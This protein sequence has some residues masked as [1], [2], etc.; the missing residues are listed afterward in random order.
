MEKELSVRTQILI[1]TMHQV[2]TSILDKM[3]I[4][5]DAVVINQ[6]DLENKRNFEYNGY[7]ITWIDTK[8][9]GLSRSRNMALKNATAEY[10]IIADDDEEFL[11]QSID[12]VE[13]AFSEHQEY[14]LLRFKI[15]GI[16][17]IFKR[18]P[19]NEEK[20][21]WIR[22]M[23]V[24]SVELAFKRQE[25]IE[26]GIEFDVCIG[27]GTQFLMGEENAFLWECLRKNKKIYYVPEII[28]NLHLGD[29]TWYEGFNSR[30]FIGK[31]AAFAAMSNR[32]ATLLIIQFALRKYRVYKKNVGLMDAIR[33]MMQGKEQYLKKFEK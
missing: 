31:G 3:N 10:C 7:S 24:S 23:K 30:Y 6:C 16:Q 29:S 25:I 12:R 5:A 8:E 21:S 28:A 11:P 4:H 13:K 26:S 15:C 19:K 27:A 1:S 32:Y 17:N 14:S 18:Y 9:R 33:F 2:D 22:S 20:I